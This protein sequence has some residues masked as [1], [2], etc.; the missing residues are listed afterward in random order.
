MS[1]PYQLFLQLGILSFRGLFMKRDWM[2][3]IL[4]L[5][6]GIMYRKSFSTPNMGCFKNAA[7]D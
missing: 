4:E 7:L 6:N 2:T 5:T 1:E 3:H